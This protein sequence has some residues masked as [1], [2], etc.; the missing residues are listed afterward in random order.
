VVR[1]GE[2]GTWQFLT[3]EPFAMSEAKLV[4]LTCPGFSDQS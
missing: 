1:D 2:D 4:A 3:G